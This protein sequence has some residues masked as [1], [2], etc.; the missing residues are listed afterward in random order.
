MG[1]EED[2][3]DAMEGAVLWTVRLHAWMATVVFGIRNC[4]IQ[5]GFVRSFWGIPTGE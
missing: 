4:E 1:G 2:I 3:E 5:R